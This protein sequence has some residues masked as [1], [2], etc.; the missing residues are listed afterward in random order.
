YKNQVKNAQEAHE[1][2]RPTDVA[3]RPQDVAAHLDRDQL[4]LYELIWKR[5]VA[6]QMQSAELDQ[7]SVDVVSD[8]RQVTL[9]ASGTV[10]VFDGF[11]TLYQEDRDDDPDDENSRLLPRMVAD[12][13]VERG[14]IKP[15]Q[16]FTQPPS[17]FSEASLV[18]R[19]EE[20]GIG[21][22]STYASIIQVLQDRDYVRLEKRRFIPE[23]RGRLVTAFLTSFFSRYVEY[24]FTANLEEQLDD[25]SGGRVDWRAVLTDFWRA[26]EPACEEAKQ[27]PFRRVLDRL[28]EDLGR[29]FFP[30]TENSKNPRQCPACADGRLGI[31]LGKREAFI[32]CSKYPECR[33]TRSLG[34]VTGNPADAELTG[35]QLLGQDPATGLDIT[36]R[37]GPFGHYVQLGEAQGETKPKRASI[38]KG[39]AIAEIDLSVALGLLSL[40][41]T[42]GPHPETGEPITAAIGRFGPY[43]KLGSRYK[44]LDPDDDVLTIGLNRAVDLLAN[45][46]GR[47][48]PTGKS[49]GAHPEDGKPVLLFE[50]GRY[51]PYVGHGKLYATLPRGTEPSEIGLD[52]AVALLAARTAR[53]GAKKRPARSK[54]AAADAT[55]GKVKTKAKPRSGAKAKAKPKTAAK[56]PAENAADD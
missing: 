20:L 42:V 52:Q 8:D 49:L 55:A 32:G 1:A 36:L 48:G 17:R 19:L 56:I 44:S 43:V 40:P 39:R 37:R 21:R 4:R 28:D 26:F 12:E 23:D 18:K 9:R 30:L 25:I 47:Q 50:T 13:P 35:P 11:L 34:V 33:Y 6:S 53:G 54:P 41:R 5:T 7:T 16:H 45:A 38:P 14:E 2:I 3:R 51:G 46:K 10:V 24:G 15:E 29:H 27:L 22:P 31:K